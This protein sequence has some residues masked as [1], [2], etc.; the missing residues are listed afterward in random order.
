MERVRAAAGHALLEVALERLPHRVLLLVDGQRIRNGD[1]VV[2]G[3]RDLS[4]TDVLDEP[5]EHPRVDISITAKRGV[6][7]VLADED[8]VYAVVTQA[9]TDRGEHSVPHRLLVLGRVEAPDTQ[10]SLEAIVLEFEQG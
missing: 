5:C 1:D 10:P 8:R 9:R 3:G 7:L 4:R 6:R 2:S